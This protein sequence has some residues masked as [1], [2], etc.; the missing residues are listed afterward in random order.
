MADAP[1]FD[2][3]PSVVLKLGEE[4]IADEFTAIIEAAKNS[5]DAGAKTID[6]DINT[7]NPPDEKF[8]SLYPDAKG[9]ITITD[10]GGGMDSDDI[11]AGWLLISYSR[12]KDIKRAAFEGGRKLKR[13]PLGDKGIGRLGMQRLGDNLELFTSTGEGNGLQVGFTWKEFETAQSLRQVKVTVQPCERKLKRGTTLLIS[14]LKSPHLWE[15]QK[16]RD[17]LQSKL[18]QMVSPFDELRECE[19]NARLNNSALDLAQFSKKILQVA[20]LHYDFELEGRA[21]RIRGEYAFNYVRLA[22]ESR[23]EVLA[24]LE[25]DGGAKLFEHLLQEPEFSGSDL[26]R[27]NKQT[28]FIVAKKT[29]DI[30]S[31]GG[32]ELDA[33][34]SGCAEPSDT[35]NVDSNDVGDGSGGDVPKVRKTLSPGPFKGEFFH[36]DRRER[37]GGFDR[38]NEFKEFLESQRGVRIYKN[39]FI[40][41]RYGVDG[42]DW[43]GLGDAWTGGGSWYGLKPGNILGYVSLSA[44]GN[45]LLIEKTDREGLTDSAA[46]NNFMKLV[47][48]V[49]SFANKVNEDI[50]RGLV[51]YQ[52]KVSLEAS[53]APD[54]SEDS[55]KLQLGRARN[56]AKQVGHAMDKAGGESAATKKEIRELD[57][58]ISLAQALVSE[59]ERLKTEMRSTVA[60]ASLGLTAEA[61]S[62]EIGN[63]VNHLSDRTKELTAIVRRGGVDPRFVEFVEY[64]KGTVAALRKQLSYLVPALKFARERREPFDV[65]D[66]I[67]KSEEYFKGRLAEKGI[68][69]RIDVGEEPLPVRTSRGKLFQVIDN[70]VLNSEYWVD[71]QL[72]RKSDAPA[73][74][75]L[76]VKA[77][78]L[79]ISDSGPG[80]D[81][82]IEAEL[83]KP[84]V[85]LKPSGRG[86]GL[87]VTRQLLDSMGCAI[88]LRSDRNSLGRRYTFEM[89]LSGAL[90]ENRDR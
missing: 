37:A 61:L 67:H 34:M 63:I 68:E 33:E 11:N 82:S 81:P 3:H 28:S 71:E 69:L 2:I 88:I 65:R 38:I 54:V 13:Y 4:L 35:K 55:V 72:R 77:P 5:Y 51:S 86:L 14:G 75:K 10:D 18:S 1:T 47:Q 22:A 62:H 73:W 8:K 50:R 89:D 27:S 26:S 59:V 17:R 64:V 80:I 39:G 48:Q 57:K 42:N 24:S 79:L 25:E 41:G 60:M 21:L 56:A 78:H 20:E 6:I 53:E 84:F 90:D 76:R 9:T 32:M 43:L 66:L 15:G 58:T 46:S 44:A 7:T 36:F 49:V 29:I 83:F 30:D 31:L 85:T 16:G 74:I 23:S 52:K 19:L 40:F 70:L 12:K 45:P 87:Y